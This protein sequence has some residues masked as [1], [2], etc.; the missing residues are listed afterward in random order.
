MKH[1]RLR[2]SLSE[3]S[4]LQMGPYFG[5]G[6]H[7][8]SV[9]DVFRNT[10]LHHPPFTSKRRYADVFFKGWYAVLKKIDFRS[11]YLPELTFL[12]LIIPYFYPYP[13]VFS[14]PF[15]GGGRR[16]YPIGRAPLHKWRKYHR[17]DKDSERCR[18]LSNGFVRLADCRR[19]T[20]V[21]PAVNTETAFT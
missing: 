12:L 19:H 7:T 17:N 13:V 14:R 2:S 11:V 18:G 8:V 3:T 5:H 21:Q 9:S 6:Y 10:L 4:G 16:R 15:S 1:G 20:A